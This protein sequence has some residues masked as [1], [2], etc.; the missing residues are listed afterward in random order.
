[1]RTSYIITLLF[2]N[3]PAAPYCANG[4]P[5]ILNSSPGSD[6]FIFAADHVHALGVSNL[7]L[8]CSV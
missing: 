4:S 5:G 3:I 8:L 7:L 2:G 1:M 6:S